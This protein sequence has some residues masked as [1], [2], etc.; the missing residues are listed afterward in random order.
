[1]TSRAR[2]LIGDDH[3]VVAQRL[4]GLLE[5]EFDVVAIVSN[6]SQLVEAA[7]RLQPDVVVTDL[8]MPGVSGLDALRRLK[9][10]G[11]RA[12]VIVLTMHAEPETAEEALRTG[13]MGFVVKDNAGEELIP[14]I[15]RVLQGGVYVSPRLTSKRESF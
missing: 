10:A 15:D 2:V 3:A 13:A 9:A 8:S 1:M 4:N 6:G 14:A 11:S 7:T 5:D 12:R